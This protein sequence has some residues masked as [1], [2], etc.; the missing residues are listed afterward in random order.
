MTGT[1]GPPAAVGHQDP[2]FAAGWVVR[3]A[4]LS[5]GQ[6]VLGGG[7]RNGEYLRARPG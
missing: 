3:L 5:P 6:R 4:G 7:C 1:Q 2:Y